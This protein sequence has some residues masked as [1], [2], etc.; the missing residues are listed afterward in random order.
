MKDTEPTSATQAFE[1]ALSKSGSERYVLI[2]YITGATPRSTQAI[3][4]IKELCEE[5][6]QGRY[7]LEVV[8]I[9]QQPELAKHAQ[10]LAAPSLVKK[11]PLPLRRLIGN[12]SDSKRVLVGLDLRPNGQITPH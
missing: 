10:I 8:D 3:L 11:L 1:E 4:R 12:L 9:Y 7:E 2:L 6:L 5:Y